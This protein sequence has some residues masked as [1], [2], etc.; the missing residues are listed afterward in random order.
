MYCWWVLYLRLSNHTTCS[1]THD[2]DCFGAIGILWQGI[3]GPVGSVK[4]VHK[5]LHSNWCLEPTSSKTIVEF[6]FCSVQ[7]EL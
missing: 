5:L 6:L 1:W 7:A 2:F 3:D 4:E